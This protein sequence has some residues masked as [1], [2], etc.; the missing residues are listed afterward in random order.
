MFYSFCFYFFYFTWLTFRC[1]V[2]ISILTLLKWATLKTFCFFKTF[3]ANVVL[4][5][6]VFLN[7][8]LINVFSPPA[9]CEPP[10]NPAVRFKGFKNIKHKDTD[11]QSHWQAS[12]EAPHSKS[13]KM[14]PVSV[15]LTCSLH[16][17]SKGAYI[18]FHHEVIPLKKLPLVSPPRYNKLQL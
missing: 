10:L 16:R 4:L 17:G 18:S 6:C 1:S 15:Y 3:N 5:V 9:L 11:I 7:I 8:L 12:L 14:F 2:N 13:M